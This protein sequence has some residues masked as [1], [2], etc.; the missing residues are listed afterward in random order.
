MSTYDFIFLNCLVILGCQ[1]IFTLDGLGSLAWRCLFAKTFC[2]DGRRGANN[3]L[4]HYFDKVTLPF[5][6]GSFYF[7]WGSIYPLSLVQYGLLGSSSSITP[8]LWPQWLIESRHMAQAGPII[9]TLQGGMPL[10]PGVAQLELPLSY[11]PLVRGR[12]VCSGGGWDQNKK[13]QRKEMK[14]V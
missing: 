11:L 13:N 8:L 7:F 14:K 1:L 2:K 9:L 3:S 10:S 4:R 6:N 5:C 12:T